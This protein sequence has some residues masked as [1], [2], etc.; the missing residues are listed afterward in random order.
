M[1]MTKLERQ[2]KEEVLNIL[3]EEGYPTY[4]RLL[5]MFEVNLTSDPNVVG[6]MEPSKGR[7]V[8]NKGLDIDQVSVVARHEILHEYLTHE[9]R[10]LKHLAQSMGLDYDTL[11]DIRIKDLK[12][13]LY[14]NSNYNI[15]ADYEISNRGYTDADKET[16]R[17]I[18]LNGKTL[19]GLVTEDEHPDWTNMSVEEMYDELNK[20]M[21]QQQ[22]QQQQQQSQQG[23]DSSDSDG[24]QGQE[25]ESSPQIGDKGDSDI[26]QAEEIARKAE[27]IAEKAKEISKKQNSGDGSSNDE[28][29]SDEDDSNASFGGSSSDSE[30]F[31]GDGDESD[32]TD[33]SD[34]DGEEGD[35]SESTP[36]ANTVQNNANS[37]G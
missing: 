15:A 16:I 17:N 24:S 35:D 12:K 2:A 28:E 31:D 25:G 21:Q 14:K 3:R 26:Q 30:D 29:G 5:N 8:L 10:L 32:A 9:M 1:S 23:D 34:S 4:A 13:D 20:A 19:S 18:Q 7:I 33:S 27:E 37:L 22:Q 6:Y 36:D 11:D